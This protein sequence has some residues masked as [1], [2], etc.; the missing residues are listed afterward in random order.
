MASDGVK[1]EVG[2]HP[3]RKRGGENVNMDYG[4][5]ATFVVDMTPGILKRWNRMCT[6]ARLKETSDAAY[7]NSISLNAMIQKRR[8]NIGIMVTVAHEKNLEAAKTRAA[9]AQEK[10]EDAQR[11]MAERAVK[12]QDKL[13]K[14]AAKKKSGGA[15]KRDPDD[16]VKSESAMGYA[17]S[18]STGPVKSEIA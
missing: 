4:G 7:G 12:K 11:K 18:V 1:D 3:K 5:K 15:T 17:G 6:L 16:A 13:E 8:D 9:K 10:L 14:A 2:D